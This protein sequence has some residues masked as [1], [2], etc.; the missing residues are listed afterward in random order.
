MNGDIEMN[1]TV[2][3]TIRIPKE[4]DDRIT[5]FVNKRNSFG[6]SE[7]S[8]D[9][10]KADWIRKAIKKEIKNQTPISEHLER[11]NKLQSVYG[12]VVCVDEDQ[13][14]IEMDSNVAVELR[15][16]WTRF[17]Q[18]FEYKSFEYINETF[19]I[20]DKI[21]EL[22]EKIGSTK[23]GTWSIHQPVPIEDTI[24]E[25]ICSNGF[26]IDLD[27]N[28]SRIDRTGRRRMFFDGAN[29]S[30]SDIASIED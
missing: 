25:I 6:L 20:Q 11:Y 16:L 22:M 5:A 27:V 10:T 21:D 23:L 18:T 12:G 19:G 24:R 28:Y 7:D 13:M 2:H 15:Q 9:Y 14:D 29:W 17:I 4:W 8:P 30:D 26:K 1:K 3:S